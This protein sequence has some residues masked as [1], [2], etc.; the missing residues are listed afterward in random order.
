MTRKP[1]VQLY[2]VRDHL[3]DISQREGTLKRLADIGFTAVEPFDPTTDP[4]GFRALADDLGLS[5]S[6][7]HAMALVREPDTGPVFEALATIGT[8]LAIL[9]AGI[10]EETFTTHD[11]LKRAAD[12][13]NALAAKAAE[14]GLR[15]GYHNHWWEFEPVLEG[16]HALEILVDLVDPAVVFEVDT[17]WATVGGAD[18][19]AVLERLGERVVALHVKDGPTVKGE[20]N[21]AVG[22][23]AM[24]VPAVLAAAP[25]AWRV[26]EFDECATDIFE[27]LA[28]SLAY[29]NDLEGT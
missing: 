16:R 19:A 20:P 27:A 22:T 21:V 28:Q 9:P 10:P 8:D 14:A 15:F 25:D 24:P 17:Y 29:V 23:G 5:V 4:A 18:A 12:Q 1:S 6:G 2:T 13:L 11:G 3:T 26:I 7:A